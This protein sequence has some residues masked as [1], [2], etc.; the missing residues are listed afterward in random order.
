VVESD[1]VAMLRALAEED[2]LRGFAEI[3]A[4]TGTGLPERGEGTTSIRH[5]Y[6]P[7]GGAPNRAAGRCCCEG[8][9]TLDG[10]G[11]GDRDE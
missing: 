6:G 5:V 10:S 9:E 2:A 3:V 7:W 4:V 1:G 11:L 8:V